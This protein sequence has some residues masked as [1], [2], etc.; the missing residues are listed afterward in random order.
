MLSARAAT[1]RGSRQAWLT[2]RD[3]A[4][5]STGGDS[6]FKT[7]GLGMLGGTRTPRRPAIPDIAPG[8]RAAGKAG[9]QDEGPVILPTPRTP[10]GLGDVRGRHRQ[11]TGPGE[12]STHWGLKD[13]E[14]PGPGSGYG[15][16]SVRGDDVAQ[17]FK[18]GQKVGVAEYRD[19]CGEA[20]YQS[21]VREPLGKSWVRGHRLPEE[22]L[23]ADFPGFGCPLPRGPPAK[24]AVFPRGVEPDSET[25]KAQYRLTHASFDPGEM[26]SRDYKWP[27]ALRNPKHQFGAAERKDSNNRGFGVKTALTMDCGIEPLSLPKTHVVMAGLEHYRYLT[28]DRLGVPKCLLQN[29]RELPEG[30]KFGMPSGTD[31]TS[32]GELVR[33]FYS[34][35]E[36][37]P[38]EDLGCCT[39]RGRRNF[40]TQQPLGIPTVRDD[41]PAPPRHRRSVACATNFGDD[42]D[43]RTLLAP[44]KFQLQN[45]FDEDFWERRPAQELYGIIQ[46][47]G[48]QVGHDEFESIFK[49][50]VEL[51]GDDEGTASLEALMVAFADWRSHH[52]KVAPS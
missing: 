50:A 36:Q 5:S 43:A 40:L 20:I 44:G 10:E 23:S 32:A 4:A 2:P 6:T 34:E 42:A 27:E 21:R 45:V 46:G 22:T 8:V 37:Q 13:A 7:A 30:H 24:D 19:A 25:A 11:R 9:G 49:Y 1:P 26:T 12:I 51:H 17:N 29:E 39:A 35:A 38:D 47:A 15:R 48:W 52:S 16:K 33:G 14:F 28:T 31:T 18:A 41:I 3:P